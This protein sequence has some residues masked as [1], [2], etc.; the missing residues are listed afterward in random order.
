MLEP[1]SEGAATLP[2]LLAAAVDGL[3]DAAG[4]ITSSPT[5]GEQERNM[6]FNG[7]RAP[8]ISLE[9]YLNRIA[10]FTKCSPACFVA[11][12]AYIAA[13]YQRDPGLAPC[14]LNVHRLLLVSLLLANKLY[15]DKRYS[16]SFWARVGGIT[17]TEINAL[18]LKMMHLLEFRLLVSPELARRYLR[19][20]QA[21]SVDLSP[22]P[23]PSVST[24]SV[25][26]RKR[27]SEGGAAAGGGG[28]PAG[29]SGGGAGGG[30]FGRQLAASLR[31][32][33]SLGLSG[34]ELGHYRYRRHAGALSSGDGAS[35]GGTP[36][37]SAARG[38]GP[39]GGS[40]ASAMEHSAGGGSDSGAGTRSGSGAEAAEGEGADCMSEGGGYGGG[41]AAGGAGGGEARSDRSEVPSRLREARGSGAGT[42]ARSS[43]AGSA[44]V[45][46]ALVK[47]SSMGGGSG[48]RRVSWAE[49][50]RQGGSVSD[51]GGDAMEG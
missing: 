25:T 7:V 3:L 27:R 13:L 47:L 42:G 23:E 26:G 11:A 34:L 40:S 17:L 5:H 43:G 30:G 31:A 8:A 51:N 29:P 4:E 24:V 19:Q 41:A 50:L 45:M 33:G 37:T 16:N 46:P 12:V 18:E 10:Q 36:T 38:T 6:S 9:A 28:A 20:L 2:R 1:G 32:A 49:N 39:T 35:A 44:G 21:G 48:R 22:P 14:T 15:D